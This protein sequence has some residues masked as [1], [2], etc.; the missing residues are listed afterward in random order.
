MKIK[1]SIFWFRRDLRLKDNTALSNALKSGFP[2]VPIF[3][4]DEDILNDLEVDDARVNFIYDSLK[5]VN[6]LLNNY[7]SSLRVF[8]SSVTQV[9][10]DILSEYD[11]Q[12]VY[13][14]E[15]YEPYG[16]ERDRLV[17]SMLNQNKVKFNSFIDHVI[18]KPGEIVKENNLPYTVFTPFKNKWLK[19]FTA[20][21][22]CILPKANFTNL[23]KINFDFPTLSD[24]NFL[25]SKIKVQKI[26]LASIDDY[27]V[28]RDFPALN[29]TSYLGPHLRFG[30]VSIRSIINDLKSSNSIFLSELIWREFFIQILLFYPNVITDNFKPKYNGIIWLNNKDE[31]KLWCKGETGYPIVDA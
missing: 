5:K 6:S 24:L 17:S 20:N 16:L 11:I 23:A 14:N 9:W 18:F 7:D 15:D 22:I 10:E 26:N 12:D 19:H 13:V 28:M 21:P 27:S 2:V 30:T 25:P 3:I 1:V 4:F 8:K 29:G 31:F